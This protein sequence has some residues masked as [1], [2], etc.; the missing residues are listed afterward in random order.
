[1]T[2]TPTGNNG[3]FLIGVT[4]ILGNPVVSPTVNP[5]Q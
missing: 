5:P 1:M 3:A 4:A 2:I